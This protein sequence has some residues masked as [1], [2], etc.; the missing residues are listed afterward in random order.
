MNSHPGFAAIF[1]SAK[2]VI[3][4][5]HLAALPGTP[6]H[7]LP[8]RE[9]VSRACAEARICRE[10]G[11]QAL[12]IENM[13]DVPYLRGGV[14]PEI[15]AAMTLVAQAVRSETDLPLGLQILAAADLEA[16]AV[17]HVAG[18]D[19][20]RVECFSFAHVADEGLMQSNAA[21][22]LRYRR[23]IGADKVQV[24]AD[25]KKKHS[26]HALTAD[27]SIGDIAEAAGFM[28]ADAVIVTGTATGRPPLPA[29]VAGARAGCRLPLLI[30]SGVSSEN[31]AGFLKTADGVIVGS[32]LKKDG[33][34]SNAVDAERLRT[35]VS[36]SR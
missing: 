8:M 14:G 18:L 25:I 5:I 33:V 4:M 15:V 22:L 16:L 30:G 21:S 3:A 10:G 34:W 6:R 19:F 23:Q 12:M 13:H 31:I 27:L 35:V 9:I 24:W 36:A 7:A 26:S 32:A 29:D 17:A 2:P 20:I 28:G 1:G 11:V